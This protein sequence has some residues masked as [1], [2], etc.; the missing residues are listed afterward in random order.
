ME[1]KVCSFCVDSKTGDSFQE[2]ATEH[3][4]RCGKGGCKRHPVSDTDC[5][6][7]VRK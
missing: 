6:V 3:C 2:P 7:K 5:I 1:T 4:P